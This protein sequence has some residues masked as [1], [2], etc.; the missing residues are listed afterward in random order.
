[1]QVCLFV[2]V[3]PGYDDG[4]GA[5][6]PQHGAG[7]SAAGLG[8]RR[9]RLTPSFPVG[10]S[11]GR[12]GRASFNVGALIESFEPRSVSAVKRN[13]GSRSSSCFGGGGKGRGAWER[14][15][16]LCVAN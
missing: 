13:A 1:M 9:L 11:G 2:P 15:S 14:V 10:S 4:A 16:N 6:P 3:E 8:V 7:A 5:P 12:I